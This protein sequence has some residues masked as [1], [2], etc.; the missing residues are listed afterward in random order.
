[1]ILTGVLPIIHVIS[2]NI[3]L[4]YNG[5]RL[6]IGKDNTDVINKKKL[7]FMIKMLYIPMNGNLSIR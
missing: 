4:H 2:Y 6:Y 1:M 3:R 5:T 7:Y